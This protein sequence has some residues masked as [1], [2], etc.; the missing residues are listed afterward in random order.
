MTV[1]VATCTVLRPPP[2][3]KSDGV[4]EKS[5]NVES[6]V[7]VKFF[8]IIINIYF[9]LVKETRNGLMQKLSNGR[10]CGEQT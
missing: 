4:R 6:D 8:I 5:L 9:P 10:K 7:K 1:A 3:C 2:W